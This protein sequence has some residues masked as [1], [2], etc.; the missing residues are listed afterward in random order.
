MTFLNQYLHESVY[1]VT[2]FNFFN[3]TPILVRLKSL[4]IEKNA[5]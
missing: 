3:G 1:V 4:E 5:E 2:L